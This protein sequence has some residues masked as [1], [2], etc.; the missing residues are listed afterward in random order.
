[1]RR[2]ALYKLW[3]AMNLKTHCLGN[4]S[5][6]TTKRCEAVGNRKLP[7]EFFLLP[8]QSGKKNLEIY[9]N[10]STEGGINFTSLLRLFPRKESLFGAEWPTICRSGENEATLPGSPATYTGAHDCLSEDEGDWKMVR[11]VRVGPNTCPSDST[12]HMAPDDR[13]CSR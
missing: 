13:T 6:T 12:L 4:D 7:M 11:V 8:T 2:E 10:A 5:K 3:L 9:K 1:M